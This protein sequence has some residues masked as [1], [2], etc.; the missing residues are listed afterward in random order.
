MSKKPHTMPEEQ[1][2]DDLIR[3]YS[4]AAAK[5]HDLGNEAAAAA[6]TDTVFHLVNGKKK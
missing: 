6:L 1:K 4:E 5:A 3:D 2:R